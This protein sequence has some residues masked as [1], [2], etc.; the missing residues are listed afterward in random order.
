[1]KKL[2]Y[3]LITLSFIVF[4]LLPVL[5]VLGHSMWHS[6]S[7][8]WLGTE[9]VWNL[10]VRSLLIAGLTAS[11]ASFFGIIFGFLLART[12]I[13]GKHGLK[14]LLLIPLLISPYIQAVAWK[15]IFFLLFDSTQWI[16]SGA[17]VIFVHTIIFVPLCMLI[18]SGAFIHIQRQLEEAGRMVASSYQ[19]FFKITLPLIK[20]AALTA[21]VLTFIISL[22]EFSVPAFYGVSLLTTEIFTQFAAFYNHSLAI[23]QSFLLVAACLLLLLVERNYLKDAP[24]LSVGKRGSDF[25]FIDLGR[26][27][28]ILSAFMW[29]YTFVV[30]ALPAIIL[31]VQSFSGSRDH[32]VEASRLLLPVIGSS[33][34]LALV[35][36]FILVFISWLW[37]QGSIRW[38]L[39]KPDVWLL[40][41]FALPSTVLGISFIK[42]YNQP[43]LQFLYGSTAMLWMGLV[44]KLAFLSVKLFQNGLQQLPVSMEEAARMAGANAWQRWRY[45][46]LPLLAD[47][48]FS[49][50]MLVFILSLGELGY[51][52]MVYPP[53][54]SLMPI[55][56]FTIMANAPAALTSSMILIAWLVSLLCLFFLY[57]LK[58]WF[59][60]G[61]HTS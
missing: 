1:M 58:V 52:I 2:L 39:P 27:R 11:C 59:M 61:M 24:F 37:A 26:W 49:A 12:S 46:Q 60:K 38:A 42:A 6:D 18:F 22:S 55:K 31:Y 3:W 13:L 23:S 4:I 33:F 21:W 56:I 10:L 57:R 47:T 28:M 29:I 32:L 16:Y 17:G 15:D 9:S 25:L 44:G 40:I 7:W 51:T 41:T 48:A 54:T 53:G 20:P 14:I 30:V 35:T 43:L 45:I 50:F 19:V 5:W 36:S 8:Q 34:Q